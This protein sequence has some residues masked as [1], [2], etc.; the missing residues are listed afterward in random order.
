MMEVR[1]VVFPGVTSSTLDSWTALL[2]E[3]V[4]KSLVRRLMSLEEVG[5]FLDTFFILIAKL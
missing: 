4:V 2:G 5:A 1:L 3:F